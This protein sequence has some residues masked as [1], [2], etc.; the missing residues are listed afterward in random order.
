MINLKN[1]K[2]NEVLGYKNDKTA[3]PCWFNN[4]SSIDINKV[5]I[6]QNMMLTKLLS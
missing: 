1:G 5:S 3:Q 2:D 6:Q 4:T